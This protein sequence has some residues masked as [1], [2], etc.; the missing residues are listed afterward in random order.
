MLLISHTSMVSMD[1]HN[2]PDEGSR[3]VGRNF[4]YYSVILQARFLVHHHGTSEIRSRTEAASVF[5]SANEV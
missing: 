2:H 5:P 3:T 1:E 4:L